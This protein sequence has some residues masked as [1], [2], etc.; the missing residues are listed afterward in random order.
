MMWTM[1]LPAMMSALVTRA[2]DPAEVMLMPL[3]SV[4]EKLSDWF[5]SVGR[6]TFLEW[7]KS[8]GGKSG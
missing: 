2:E 8:G 3:L 1:D 7:G 5:A 6:L 4:R